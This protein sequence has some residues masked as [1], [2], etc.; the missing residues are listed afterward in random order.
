MNKVFIYIFLAEVVLASAALA[1]QS[2]SREV[3]KLNE[4]NQVACLVNDQWVTQRDSSGA[5]LSRENISPELLDCLSGQAPSVLG[6]EAGKLK[7]AIEGKTHL[8]NPNS[9]PIK[10]AAK[11]V[12]NLVDWRFQLEASS[13]DS[14]WVKPEFDDSKW[15]KINALSSWQAQGIESKPGATGIYRYSQ[16]IPD[17]WKDSKILVQSMGVYDE[18]D[19]FVNGALVRHFGEEKGTLAWD[20][21]EADISKHLRF[22]EKNTIASRVK[23]HGE[24]GG[25]YRRIQLRRVPPFE[26]FKKMLPVPVLDARP[27]LVNLY[28]QSWRMAFK[29]LSFGTKENTFVPAYMEEG[30][31][32]QVYQWDSIF[33]SMYGRYGGKNFPAMQTLDNFYA[34]Q[35]PDGYIARIYSKTDGK[36]LDLPQ[37]DNFALTNPPLFAWSEWDYYRMS[38]DASRLARVLPLL[39]KY[40]GWLKKHQSSKSVKGMYWQTGYDSGMDNM[41]RPNADLAGWVDMSLQQALTAKYLAQ[42]AEKVGDHKK[43][44]KWKAEYK[45]RAEAINRLAWN[46]K[47]GFYYDVDENGKQ[48]GVKHIGAMW[49]ML[50]EV[51]SPEQAKQ[52]QAHLKNPAE[53]YRPHLFP[54]LSASDPGYTKEASYWRGG[55]WAPT[56]YMTIKGLKRYGNDDFAHEAALNHLTNME[57]VYSSKVDTEHVDPNEVSDDYRTIWE[58]YNPDQAVPCTRA[59]EKNYGRQDFAG[60]TALGPIALFIQEGVG[61]DIVGAENKVNWNIREK[62]QV[63]ISNMELQHD[64]IFSV[65]A[66]PEKN[67]QRVIEVSAQKPFLLSVKIGKKSKNIKVPAG[68]SRFTVS[69]G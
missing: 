33:M 36:K 66:L 69:A 11:N 31:N 14:A 59:D 54:A 39:E 30:Y 43:A 35:D 9:N 64:N 58:C 34:K 6:L 52:L 13:S 23:S 25:I 61:L 62:G 45:E 2:S 22:G 7:R 63:G 16:E 1:A 57:K 18:Y 8:E 21:T 5:P 26:T 3:C 19:I 37:E 41:P 27:E 68:A 65:L 32:E 38:G 46:K 40:D 67:S 44:E 53:F 47:D 4:G 42:I 28:W 17:S 50:A 60:W 55:V 10:E 56:N 20:P 15:T 12:V 24:K 49:A 29:N 48:T 51:A